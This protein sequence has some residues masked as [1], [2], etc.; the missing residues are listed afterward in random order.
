MRRLGRWLLALC[1]ALGLVA[2]GARAEISVYAAQGAVALYAED[3]R[4]GVQRADG[5]VLLEAQYD[6][7][8]PFGAAGCAIAVLEGRKGVVSSDGRAVI[9]PE[10]NAV[11]LCDE[12]EVAVCYNDY[13][14]QT[15]FDLRTGEVL[16]EGGERE[17][18]WASG[19][20]IGKTSYGKAGW[21]L[22][23]P[24]FT[25]VYDRSMRLL[26]EFRANVLWD[27]FDSGIAAAEFED[28]SYGYVKPDGTVLLDGLQ[29][30]GQF[31]D[32]Y[33]RYVRLET[34]RLTL[35]DHGANG[36]KKGLR[37]ALN[38]ARKTEQWRAMRA[39]R[40]R[41]P[42]LRAAYRRFAR[43]V[44]AI[45][46]GTSICGIMD[47]RGRCMEA[48]G[49]DMG[50]PDGK[51]WR[52][53]KVAGFR[54]SNS[55]GDRYGYVDES[56]GFVLPPVYERAFGFVED[57]AVVARDG[58]YFLIDRQG[59]RVGDLSWK[60]TADSYSL[61]V[62]E[63]SAVP[64]EAQGGY[65]L[66]DRQ[67]NWVSDDV[68]TEV[69]DVPEPGRYLTAR[70]QEGA[71]HFLGPNGLPL[72]PLTCE[73]YVYTMGDA[74]VIWAQQGGRWGRLNVCGPDCAPGTYLSENRYSELYFD[75]VG[76]TDG[77]EWVLVDDAG[78]AVGPVRLSNELIDYHFN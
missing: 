5:G 55:N 75:S 20:Y 68:W 49:V 13:E 33:G 47:E 17:A 69:V 65:R 27:S 63:F 72:F 73:N 46:A 64:V 52:W 10:W 15:L 50:L 18:I 6:E 21:T 60:W 29:Y 28:G 11:E 32:G 70:D 66:A 77:G 51:G 76:L 45:D 24:F 9:P 35:A 8:L 1:L 71:Y 23:P 37:A 61:A 42:R 31:S 41:F 67:G 39:H 78:N 36:L 57:A 56:G 14:R 40:S 48:E 54:L 12:A 44:D 58:E 7:I 53:V 74:E 62:F 4:V 59:R 30:A 34:S 19:M 2:P 26:G 16:I 3:G 38:A 43:A 22:E 25:Q